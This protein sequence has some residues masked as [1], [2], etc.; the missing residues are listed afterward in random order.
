MSWRIEQTHPLSLLPELP[1]QWA[2]ACI[3][4]PPQH[5]PA[6]RVVAV[7]QE[8]YRVLRTDGTVWLDLHGYQDAHELIWQ[9]R[10]TPWLR[11]LSAS[12]TPKQTLLLVK[13]P[14]FLFRAQHSPP[15]T[16]PPRRL[17][18]TPNPDGHRGAHGCGC[19]RFE[20]RASCTHA[21]TTLVG[22][23]GW[24]VLASTTRHA[25]EFCGAPSLRRTRH[26]RRPACAHHGDRGR[27]LVIDPF[28]RVRT[29]VAAVS[30][31]RHY[32][33]IEPDPTR[34]EIVRARLS[35]LEKWQ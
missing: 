28:C 17:A 18:C 12:V 31:G 13:S 9:L 10:Q 23:V 22:A 5:M 14:S 34:A 7:L 33:G 11:A 25:C 26:P 16:S 32:L 3:T 30:H 1:D 24:C 4:T 2:Q 35:L 15:R 8:M 19:R 20:R 27:C 29:G 21:S 6:P